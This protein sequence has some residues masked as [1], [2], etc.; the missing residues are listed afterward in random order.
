VRQRVDRKRA[1]RL[2]DAPLHRM[3]P[4]GAIG[5]AGGADILAGREEII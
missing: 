1:A 2:P 4:I 3:H 5:D